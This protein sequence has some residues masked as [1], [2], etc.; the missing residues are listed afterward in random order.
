MRGGMGPLGAVSI[1]SWV[2]LSFGRPLNLVLYMSFRI[3]AYS[4]HILKA[5]FD[6]MGSMPACGFD[7]CYLEVG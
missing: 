5:N 3:F 6:L 2:P 7:A 1:W 4:S